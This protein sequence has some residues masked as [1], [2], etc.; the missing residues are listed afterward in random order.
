MMKDSNTLR[1]I[2]RLL[3]A[4]H[5]PNLNSELP[6][7]SW[8]GDSIFPEGAAPEQVKTARY[9]RKSVE[10]AW[11]SFL[12]N[13]LPRDLRREVLSV[14][15][16]GILPWIYHPERLMDFL[17][18]SFNEGG[19]MSLLALSGIFQ[20][21]TEKNLD[22]PLFYQKLY[23][24]LD[25]EL[26]HS[27]HRSHFFRLFDNFMSSTHLPSN[28]V[29]SF[30]K[31]LSRLALYA[32]PAGVVVVIPWIYNMFQR[33][34]SCTF[35]MHRELPDTETTQQMTQ[36]AV[37]DPFDT[38]EKNPLET[39]AVDSSVWELVALQSH[40]HPNVAT[41]A[42]IISE[43]FTKEQYN[44]EDFLDYSYKTVNRLL[45]HFLSC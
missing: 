20:L 45:L 16:E 42:R 27:I 28:L 14:L 32:P 15:T 38:N 8:V 30:I 17:T 37:D 36:L 40:Y 33:H 41:L 22:Y 31:K 11:L 18:D 4:I 7:Q 23:S 10:E 6:N 25:E 12:K 44:L 29:A 39:G 1:A 19:D 9:R 34:P 43:Q 3:G 26:L 5:P 2:F 24:L 21:M 13:R 35:L